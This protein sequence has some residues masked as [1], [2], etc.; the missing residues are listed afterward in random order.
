MEVLHRVRGPGALQQGVDLGQDGAVRLGELARLG[1]GGAAVLGHHGQRALGEVA[2]VVGQVRVLAAHHGLVAVGAV[3]AERELAQQEEADGVQAVP[4]HPFPRVHHVAQGLGHLGPV[5]VQEAVDHDAARQL[6]AGRHE[7]RGPEDAVEPGDVLADHVQVRRPVA[8]ERL[9]VLRR[10]ARAGEVVRQRI[11]PDVGDVV[12]A[13]VGVAGVGVRG[14]RQ[15]DAPLEGGPGDGQV[16]EPGLHEADDLVEAVPGGGEVR[17]LA[18]VVQQRLLV[19]GQAEEVGLLLRPRH[20]GAGLDGA[21]HPVLTHLGLVLAEVAFV[22][23]GVPAGVG[24]EVDVPVGL[25]P[26]PDLADGLGVVR[27]RG[28]DEAV[29]GDVQDVVVHLLE[30]GRVAR[31]QLEGAHALLLRRLLHLLAVLVRAGQEAHVP[32]VEPLEAGHRVRGDVL[33]GVADVR[34]AVRVGDGRGQVVRG[35][36]VSHSRR[37]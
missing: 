13:P 6:E 9:R 11:D 16:L 14:R 15:V 21:A 36:G 27:V 4:G 25:H 35:A 33:V 3:R 1:H 20:L 18:V 31:G 24:A 17:V 29:V 22:P 5:V 23:H 7:E 12:G 37:V 26:P 30:D 10:P 8:R 2:E 32:P 19:L 34:L 28:A